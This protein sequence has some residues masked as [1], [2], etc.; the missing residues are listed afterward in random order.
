LAALITSGAVL[1]RMTA[2]LLVM[3]RRCAE[4]V[5]L[6]SR[7]TSGVGLMAIAASARAM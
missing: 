2:R 6:L 5:A 7:M 4:T 3:A 1:P